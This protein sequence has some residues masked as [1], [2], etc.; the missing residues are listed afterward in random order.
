MRKQSYS[1]LMLCV[2]LSAIGLVSSA[3]AAQETASA[4][5]LP[6]LRTQILARHAQASA[7]ASAKAFSAKTSDGQTYTYT[8]I[9]FPGS[10]STQGV[11]I[12]LDAYDAGDILGAT[13]RVVGAYLFPDD[14]SQTGFIADVAGKNIV[15]ETYQVVND[16]TGP[17]PQQAYSINDFGT[18]VGDYIDAS[19]MFHSYVKAGNRFKALDVPFAGATGTYSP[20]I[21]NAGEIVG[22]WLDSAGTAHSYTLVNGTFTSFDPPGSAQ[23]QFFYGINNQGD[24]TGSFA[25]A[26]GNIHGFLRHGKTY[27]QLDFPGAAATFP[28]AVN[29]PGVIVGAYCPTAAC[30]TTGEGETGF[31]LKDGTYTSFTIPGGVSQ[32]PR[33]HQQSRRAD[34]QLFG[35]RRLALHVLGYSLNAC[36]IAVLHASAARTVQVDITRRT[37]RLA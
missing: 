11:G 28:G 20:A 35:C 27:T 2:G 33:C 17:T 21:N 36:V 26:Q 19:G 25:D 12:N 10:L 22:G 37:R 29:D 6:G 13:T 15:A 3:G 9:A 32:C 31:L 4:A 5:R 1:I 16:P 24:I 34:G 14:S 23:G 30:L 18:V 8:L 7:P